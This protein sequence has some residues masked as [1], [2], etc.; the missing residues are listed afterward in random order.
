M[1]STA[2]S[3]DE[4][5]ATR[6]STAFSLSRP[7]VLNQTSRSKIGLVSLVQDFLFLTIPPPSYTQGNFLFDHRLDYAAAKLWP[8]LKL[9]LVPLSM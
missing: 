1:A 4:S 5:T 2:L 6:S 9:P 3:A 8:A 7:M